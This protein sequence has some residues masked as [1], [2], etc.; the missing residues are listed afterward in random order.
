[1]P[2][3]QVRA[4]PLPP[5]TCAHTLAHTLHP[6]TRP[7][8]LHAH[9]LHLHL[10]RRC[11]NRPSCQPW[12][13]PAL[14]L[15]QPELS[16]SSI[17]A[18]AANHGL[19]PQADGAQAGWVLGRSPLREPAAEPAA[20]RLL[21]AARR[22]RLAQTAGPCSALAHPRRLRALRCAQRHG[23]KPRLQQ[24]GGP[25]RGGGG[26]AQGCAAGGLLQPGRLHG[27]CVCGGGG[28]GRG[29]S[30]GPPMQRQRHCTLSAARR[31]SRLG[32]RPAPPCRPC[33]PQPLPPPPP[34]CCCC[35]SRR[36]PA[37]WACRR[38]RS[39]RPSSCCSAA[40][41][42]CGCCAAVTGTGW[43]RAGAGGCR[44]CLRQ[45]RAQGQGAAAAA[46]APGGRV[47]RP[48]A[49]PA[50]CLWGMPCGAELA[51]PRRPTPHAGTSRWSSMWSTPTTEQPAA[52]LSQGR[53]MS[54][55]AQANG[56][57]YQVHHGTLCGTTTATHVQLGARA[58]PG[59][60]MKRDEGVYCISRRVPY[61]TNRGVQERA[62]LAASAQRRP[63][64]QQAP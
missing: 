24:G 46:A 10:C 50:P 4:P 8:P 28:G 56:R 22:T 33:R 63:G 61:V 51:A 23:D 27:V 5:A 39:S 7:A 20:T 48:C 14:P 60:M 35:R 31:C 2:F 29:C 30:R 13:A 42:T 1:V 52:A 54:A 62:A 15:P 38:A 19:E 36:R 40:T 21:P 53:G 9:A 6:C 64:G 43:R 47:V 25:G 41:P 17:A 32:G 11:C 12:R 44:R 49:G 34:P 58:V 3:Y 37:N 57:R 18:P 16:A 45:G 55:A 59:V 26:R